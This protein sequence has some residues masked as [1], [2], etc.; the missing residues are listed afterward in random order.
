MVSAMCVFA[1]GE[2]IARHS[3]LYNNRVLCGYYTMNLEFNEDVFTENF[4]MRIFRPSRAKMAWWMSSNEFI[5]NSVNFTCG[6]L[7]KASECG[8]LLAAIAPTK[9]KDFL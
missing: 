5:P 6:P 4:R 1:E 7:H 9:R 8:I 2:K 3:N